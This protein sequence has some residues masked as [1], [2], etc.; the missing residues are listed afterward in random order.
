MKKSSGIYILNCKE[1]YKIGI[2]SN[3]TKRKNELQVGNPFKINIIYFAKVE[4][5]ARLESI[6][7]EKFWSK[8]V[9]GEW[10]KLNEKDLEEAKLLIA[11]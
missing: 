11:K 1:F 9:S 3:I 5:A 7:H 8:N 2:T 6:L 4:N 10:F